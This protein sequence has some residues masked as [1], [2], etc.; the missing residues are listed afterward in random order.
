MP[1]TQPL[2]SPDSPG[3]SGMHPAIRPL[4]APPPAP[5]APPAQSAGA[6]PPSVPAPAPPT[7]PAQAPGSKIRAF[8]QKLGG[9]H[10]SENWKR[11]PRATGSGAVHVKSFHCKLNAE[12][13]E[14]LDKQIN[15]WLD[16]HP[17]YEVK[18]SVAT[19]GEWT[20]K[21]KEPSLIVQVWV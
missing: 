5:G 18:F 6:A 10:V 8:E 17:D 7:A 19:V 15:E 11:A 12:S 16:A 13:L 21:I 1:H 14:Y 2:L 3:S 20:G 4:G 9:G